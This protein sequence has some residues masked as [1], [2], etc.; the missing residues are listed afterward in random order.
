MCYVV[1]VKTISVF[2]MERWAEARMVN[3]S[4]ATD[5]L[6]LWHSFVYKEVIIS[7]K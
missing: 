5:F 3:G 2:I 4:P 1:H 6:V 7:Y